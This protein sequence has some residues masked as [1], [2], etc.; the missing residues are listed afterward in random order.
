MQAT[1]RVMMR[2]V[3]CLFAES[4]QLLPTNDPIYGQ[5]YGVRSL[6]ELLDEAVGGK[7]Y[8][9]SDADVLADH[10]DAIIPCQLLL[11]GVVDG[12]D[13]VFYRDSSPP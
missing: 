7:K 9:A 4:R 3:V 10:E 2:L 13:D 5:S 6:Y 8:P 12:F 11:H 1:V